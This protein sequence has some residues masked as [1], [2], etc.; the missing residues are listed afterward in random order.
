MRNGSISSP[1]PSRR[2]DLLLSFQ[3]S[4]A[5]RQSMRMK[6]RPSYPACN[7]RPTESKNLEACWEGCMNI[8]TLKS[9]TTTSES[10]LL[11]PEVWQRQGFLEVFFTTKETA[12]AVGG[13]TAEAAMLKARSSSSW[14]S[15]SPS[16]ITRQVAHILLHRARRLRQRPTATY[17]LDTRALTTIFSSLI[18][19]NPQCRR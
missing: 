9:S 2:K 7:R 14:I 8:V 16:I 13:S 19:T 12:K 10:I 11:A 6:P 5:F 15:S 17:R 4:T 1:P 18:C 3:C